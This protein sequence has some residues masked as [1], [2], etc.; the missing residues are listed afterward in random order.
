MVYIIILNFF[1]IKPYFLTEK[2]MLSVKIN[3]L[4]YILKMPKCDIYLLSL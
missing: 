3:V 4:F 1:M 2:P